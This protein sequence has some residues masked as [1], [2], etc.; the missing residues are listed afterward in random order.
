MRNVNLIYGKI[1][2]KKIENDICELPEML[3]IL[4]GDLEVKERTKL[5]QSKVRTIKHLQIDIHH[6][7]HILVLKVFRKNMYFATKIILQTDAS[8]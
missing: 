3:K 5:S 6:M 8:K 7:R 4:K 2:Q 1:S